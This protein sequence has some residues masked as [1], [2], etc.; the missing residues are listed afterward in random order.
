MKES[1]NEKKASLN[2]VKN[3]TKVFY[4]KDYDGGLRASHE[5]QKLIFHSRD[6]QLLRTWWFLYE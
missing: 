2:D 1:E 5:Q 4:E 3:T 6:Q